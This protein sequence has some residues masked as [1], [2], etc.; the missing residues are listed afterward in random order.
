MVRIISG[1]FRKRTLQVPRGL[2]VRPTQDR[3]KEALFNIVWM[4]L[5]F[6]FSGAQVAD[7][8]AGT[9]SLGLEALSRGAAHCTFVDQAAD[10]LRCLKHNIAL[11]GVE[12]RCQ[13]LQMSAAQSVARLPPLDIA[14]LDP[15][16][17]LLQ[18]ETLVDTL[19][20][21]GIIKPHGLCVLESSSLGEPAPFRDAQVLERRDYGDT[22]I[23]I[24]AHLNSPLIADTSD[25]GA[26]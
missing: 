23:T 3:V 17:A 25:T 24:L 18:V 10:S 8:F 20:A 14:F 11:L 9:G 22:R 15:P 21:R 5:G 26:P 12:A 7:L 1:Q 13:V 2:A 4:R 6:E 19:F 16:Y